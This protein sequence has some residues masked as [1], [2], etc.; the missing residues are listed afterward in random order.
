MKMIA[1]YLPQF[2]EIPE[3]NQWWGDGFTEWTNTRKAEPLFPGHYQPREPYQDFYYDLTDPL[4]RQWQVDIAKKYGIYGFCYYHYWFKGKRLLEKPFNEVLRTGKPDFPFCLSWANEPWTRR[5]D[6]RDDQ[7]LMPQHYGNENDWKEHFDYLL[8]AFQD[9]RYICVEEKPLFLI[10][11]PESI[12]NCSEMLDYWDILAKQNGLKG[13]YFVRTLNGHLPLSKLER[14]NASVEFEPH[15]TAAHTNCP[16]I[17][18]MVSG[19][20]KR[21]AVIDYDAI[22][23]CILS[24]KNSR[25]DTKI[26]PGAFLDWDNTARRGTEATI[27]QGATPE[28]FEKYLSEQIKRAETIYQSEFLF[29]NAWNEWAE[30]TYLEPDKQNQFRYIEAVKKA[31]KDNGYN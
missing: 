15:Y 17:W 2:H 14:F 8:N 12:P 28:K 21:K 6:G 30:G 19:Y 29:I 11:R 26:F 10:Y 1:F 9:E 24:R 4:V 23:S 27:Y 7:V 16:N 20:K 25:D 13:I 22:W 31:L 5:W 3:N 18:R